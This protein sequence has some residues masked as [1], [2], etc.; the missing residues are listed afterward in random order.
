MKPLNKSLRLIK[1]L[2]INFYSGKINFQITAATS[3]SDLSSNRFKL[4][5]RQNTKVVAPR[6]LYLPVKFQLK[7]SYRLSVM[8]FFL[9]GLQTEKLFDV[10]DFG[11]SFDHFNLRI[12]FWSKHESRRSMKYLSVRISYASIGLPV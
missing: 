6:V 10:F 4:A 7:R 2:R 11:L 3:S 8:N 1:P 9:T 5:L 12:K